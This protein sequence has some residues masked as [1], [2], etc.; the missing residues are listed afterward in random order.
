MKLLERF[1]NY[2]KYD[3]QSDSNSNSYPSTDKQWV[4]L[5]DLLKEL[6]EMGVLA[7]I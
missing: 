3:T 4:L 1:L 6:N 7:D 2:V 5:K